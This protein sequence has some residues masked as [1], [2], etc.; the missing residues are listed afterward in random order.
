MRAATRNSKVAESERM[1]VFIKKKEQQINMKCI[2]NIIKWYVKWWAKQK[3]KWSSFYD[4]NDVRTNGYPKRWERC[5]QISTDT[6]I[7]NKQTN[8][9]G[10]RA[11]ETK[12]IEGLSGCGVVGAIIYNI[13]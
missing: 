8:A 3:L 12:E 10:D 13:L 1:N 11:S 6:H 7:H 2:W 4:A 5:I 9:T